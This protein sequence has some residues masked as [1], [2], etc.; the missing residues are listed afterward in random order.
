MDVLRT[1]TSLC[2]CAVSPMACALQRL[3]DCGH[4]VLPVLKVTGAA[5]ALAHVPCWEEH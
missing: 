2:S 4:E 5:F 3:G 1:H